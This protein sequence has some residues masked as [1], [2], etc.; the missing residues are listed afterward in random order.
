[1]GEILTFYCPVCKFGH[2][3][4]EGIGFAGF[5]EYMDDRINARCIKAGK[6]MKNSLANYPN[7]MISN[8]H[9][10]AICET[11]DSFANV[12]ELGMYVPTEE[13]VTYDKNGQLKKFD[14]NYQYFYR[15]P[16]YY[17][18]YK[19]YPHKCKKCGGVMKALQK[20][21][22]KEIQCPNCGH[23]YLKV[24]QDGNWD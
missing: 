19:R 17:K 7:G 4:W 15:K 12:E 16:Y 21:E 6:E 23:R 2:T 13:K 3:L 8:R 20:N 9:T 22:F 24:S 1:M 11:C 5:A 10:L 18:L 14:K